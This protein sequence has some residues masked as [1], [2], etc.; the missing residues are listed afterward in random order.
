MWFELSVGTSSGTKED[1][2]TWLNGTIS[3][4]QEVVK[5]EIWLMSLVYPSSTTRARK[6]EMVYVLEATC[7]VI[8]RLPESLHDEHVQNIATI[9]LRADWSA[10]V[11][12]RS[13]R[14]LDDASLLSRLKWS[15]HEE[16]DGG[17]SRLW[18]KRIEQEGEVGVVK[19]SVAERYIL[20]CVVSNG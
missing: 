4:V 12:E 20:A 7:E 15:C 11:A 2:D 5:S 18:L 9:P 6:Q 17:I 3:D 1:P 14:S 13:A 10:Y 16:Y 19:R 8:G